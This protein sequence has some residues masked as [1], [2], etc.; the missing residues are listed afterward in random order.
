VVLCELMATGN[1]DQ[2]IADRL[3]ITLRDGEIRLDDQRRTLDTPE[4]R[5]PIGVCPGFPDRSNGERLDESR[6]LPKERQ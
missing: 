2:G 3:V 4:N 5:P 1:S 6:E